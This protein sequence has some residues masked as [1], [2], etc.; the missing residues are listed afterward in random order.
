MSNI[1]YDQWR[2]NKILE[3]VN[4]DPWQAKILFENYFSDYPNDYSAYSY[5]AS[6]LITIGLFDQA[7]EILNYVEEKY[8]SDN[9][10]LT[11][12]STEKSIR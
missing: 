2:F 7:N 12:N 3:K 9:K 5:Y 8:K 11:R 6:C 1:Y 10:Y 4:T